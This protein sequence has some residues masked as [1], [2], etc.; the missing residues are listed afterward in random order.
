MI[1]KEKLFAIVVWYNP[2]PANVETIRT[3]IGDVGKLI[4]VDNSKDDNA[5]L[6]AGYSSFDVCYLPN[7]KNLGVATALNQGC[8][9]AIE[10][11]AEWVLTM[12]QD[13]S[14][15]ENGV[16]ELVEKA[17]LYEDF[18]QTVIFS[19][20]HLCNDKAKNEYKRIGTYTRENT[21]MTSGNLLS[22]D[23]YNRLG[24]FRDEFF[25]DLVDEEFCYRAKEKGFQVV[26]V[27]TVW[28]NHRLGDACVPINFF[29]LKKMFYDYNPF[30]RYYI[31]R[32]TLYMI[33]LFPTYKKLFRRRLRRQAKRIILYDDRNK[34]V[35]LK[36]ILKG[37][38]DYKKGI[39]GPLVDESYTNWKSKA[40]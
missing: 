39:K 15:N 23:I 40:K 24:R 9:S 22:L 32:N 1:Q 4:V 26:T 11:G 3:Y 30:R 29:G 28:L 19:P 6:L 38:K 37:F 8:L 5:H 17:N 7:R 14:F 2:S 12:D 13:S 33:R 34:W 21:V 31:T 20:F 35:K 18:T 36:F 25:I 10:G 27:N 16:R